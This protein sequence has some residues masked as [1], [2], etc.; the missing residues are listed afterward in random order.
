LVVVREVAILQ[1]ERVLLAD[2]VAADMVFQMR[3]IRVVQEL[4]VKVMLVG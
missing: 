1:L 3:L 4:W 2:Q